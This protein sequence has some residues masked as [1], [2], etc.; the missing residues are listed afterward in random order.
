MSVFDPVRRSDE[1]RATRLARSTG[2]LALLVALLAL[3]AA[4]L[5]A[6][7]SD[8]SLGPVLAEA[9]GLDLDGALGAG[10]A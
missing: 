7:A 1:A 6:Q 4:P 9:A 5:A 2:V 8:V 10:G 3:G